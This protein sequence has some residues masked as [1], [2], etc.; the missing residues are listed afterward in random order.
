MMATATRKLGKC[1]GCIAEG[2]RQKE[3]EIIVTV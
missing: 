2:R 1:K 3:E